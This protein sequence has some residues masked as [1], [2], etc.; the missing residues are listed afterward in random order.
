[1]NRRGFLLST[2]AAI[3][4]PLVPAWALPRRELLAKPVPPLPYAG[5]AP[6][7]PDRHPTWA[8]DC[9]R[10][11]GRVLTGERAHWCWDF[12]GLP[13]DETT[14]EI[15]FCSCTWEHPP[16]EPVFSVPSEARPRKLTTHS[17]RC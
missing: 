13:M 8:E 2:V 10:W 9:L 15:V 14:E 12:H 7:Y 1:M 3:A 11:H 6:R 17:P 16:I 5:V 4:A